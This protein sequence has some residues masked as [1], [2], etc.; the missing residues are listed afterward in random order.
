MAMWILYLGFGWLCI[1]DV[2]EARDICCWSVSFYANPLPSC[3][4]TGSE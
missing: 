3:M 2:G 4:V 1:Q